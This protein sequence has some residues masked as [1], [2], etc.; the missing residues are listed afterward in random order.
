MSIDLNNWKPTRG[1][2]LVRPDEP[3][4][5]I[6]GIYIA[7]NPNAL[8]TE[9]KV[10]ECTVLALGPP[11]YNRTRTAEIP[12]DIKVGDRILRQPLAGRRIYDEFGKRV[13][14]V[15]RDEEIMAKIED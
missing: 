7:E 10:L 8:D 2:V 6:G 1:N 4:T 11:P 5:Q 14:V 13:A 3:K 15:L 12:W 9:G